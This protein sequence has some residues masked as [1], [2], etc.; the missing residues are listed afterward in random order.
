MAVAVVA[1]DILVGFEFTAVHF[2]REL[3]RDRIIDRLDALIVGVVPFDAV[4]LPP[5]TGVDE[6]DR[7][8][9]AVDPGGVQVGRSDDPAVL[10]LDIVRRRCA[11]GRERGHFGLQVLVGAD[12]PVRLQGRQLTGAEA[13]TDRVDDLQFVCDFTTDLLYRQHGLVQAA[14]LDD[15]RSE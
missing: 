3:T 11:Q 10:L 8:A 6:G 7:H 13:G 5:E 9:L 4:G 14:R 15:V 2:A 12:L 1:G